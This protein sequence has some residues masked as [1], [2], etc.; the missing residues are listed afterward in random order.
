MS[1]IIKSQQAHQEKSK[2]IAI[3]V[4]TFDFLQNEK[5]DEGINL[6][7][8]QSDQFQ[9]DAKQEAERVLLDAKQ[10]AQAIAAEIQQ[11]R[12][13]W[14]HQEKVMFIEQAQKEGY[15][16]G[17][18]DGFQ[19]GYNEIAGDIAFAKEVVESSKKDYRQHIE[20]SETVILNLAVKIAEK[21]IGHQLEKDEESFLS[22][23]K[24]AI[25]EA[26]DYREVQLHIHL[27]Q[28]QSILSHKEELIAIFPKDTELYIFPDDEIE[29]N[30]CII[31]SENGRIDASVNSQLQEIKVKLTE[32]LREGSNDEN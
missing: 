20:S 22:I 32:L 28:Y 4:R 2:K 8:F 6:Q 25:K 11:D 19:K 12:E 17:V 21:I 5:A 23:V 24:R 3:K 31:E 10:K 30:S 18:E 9:R 1:R 15:Q 26:R 27:V 7:H 14:E 16:Q 13:H 29:E